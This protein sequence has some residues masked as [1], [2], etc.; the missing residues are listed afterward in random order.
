MPIYHHRQHYKDKNVSLCFFSYLSSVF[1][2]VYFSCS[3]V[4][5]VSFSCNFPLL[6]FSKPCQHHTRSY[7]DSKLFSSYKIRITSTCFQVCVVLS[8]YATTQTAIRE[9]ADKINLVSV[10]KLQKQCTACTSWHYR[11][12][13][14]FYV[15]PKKL[16]HKL[17]DF[18][19]AQ[20]TSNFSEWFRRI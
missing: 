15:K 11:V 19:T 12:D 10:A 18:F 2:I 9:I 16:T 20:T 7:K 13:Y 1:P 6:W 17:Q 4:P 14:E 3:L 8:F 5:V